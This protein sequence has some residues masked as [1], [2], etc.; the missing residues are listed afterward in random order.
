MGNREMSPTPSLT[1]AVS[2]TPPR[3]SHWTLATPNLPI[4]TQHT[5]GRRPFT[6]YPHAPQFTLVTRTKLSGTRQTIGFIAV[7]SCSLVPPQ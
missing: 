4:P 3:H 5:C 2:S 1:T 7:I 6:M